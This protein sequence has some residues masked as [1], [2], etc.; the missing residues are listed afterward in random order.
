ML[1]S[2]MSKEDL[3]THLYGSLGCCRKW[4]VSLFLQANSNATDPYLFVS[5]C[6]LTVNS[7]FSEESSM[8]TSHLKQYFPVNILFLVSSGSTKNMS[9]SYF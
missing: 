2:S 7:T 6:I 1:K 4:I 9:E 3:C 8:S 5:I